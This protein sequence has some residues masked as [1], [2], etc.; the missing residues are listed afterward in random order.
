MCILRHAFPKSAFQV[1]GSFS[2]PVVDYSNSSC[3][4]SISRL[5]ERADLLWRTGDLLTSRKLYKQVL[6]LDP[7]NLTARKRLGVS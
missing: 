2:A 7:G 5:N 3:G 6:E 1:G 4:K